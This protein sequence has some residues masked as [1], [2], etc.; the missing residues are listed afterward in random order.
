LS[1]EE[2]G[3]LKRAVAPVHLEANA[4]LVHEGDD[5]DRVFTVLRGML[6]IVRYL[7]Q[8]QRHIVAFLLPGDLAGMPR[9]ET[10]DSSI[11]AVVDSELC[12]FD[13]VRLRELART[14]PKLEE[15]ALDLVCGDLRRAMDLQVS[16]SRRDPTERVAGFL[17]DLADRARALGET[18]PVISL[19]M[20]RQ[21]IA[22]HLGLTIETVSRTVS[23][24]RREGLI[25]L[26]ASHLV[27]LRHRS[28]L[29]ELA[30]RSS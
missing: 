25:G 16:L 28:A 3:Q 23:R 13:R 6:R 29:E 14:L 10:H 17:L 7:P 1:R 15:R 19:P 20:T 8:G 27:E 12:S 22:D 24:L 26:P 30:G 5:A 18:S 21:D 2:L 4:T 11:E 9:G